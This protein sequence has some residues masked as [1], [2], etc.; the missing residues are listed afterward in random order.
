M[1]VDGA[2]QPVD[3]LTEHHAHVIHVPG[4]TSV[5][6]PMLQTLGVL[7]TEPLAPR[8]DGFVTDINTSLEQEFLHVTVGK[9]EAVV[10]GVGDDR[11]GGAIALG[12]SVELGI[13]PPYLE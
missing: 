10:Y 8:S 4:S 7:G 3:L 5:R 1:F 11:F 6:F 2:P 13:A 12:R 9:G